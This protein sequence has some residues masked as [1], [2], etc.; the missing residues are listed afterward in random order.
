MV[1]ERPKKTAK[2]EGKRGKKGRVTIKKMV[3]GVDTTTSSLHGDR[4]PSEFIDGKVL[5]LHVGEGGVAFSG[6]HFL[7]ANSER[8]G[9]A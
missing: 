8:A 4:R 6:G 5:G 2:L 7:E 9:L 1:G 3:G